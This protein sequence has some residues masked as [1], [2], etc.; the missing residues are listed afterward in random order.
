LGELLG[1]EDHP[2]QQPS[3]KYTLER[4]NDYLRGSV[5]LI[6]GS[7]AQLLCDIILTKDEDIV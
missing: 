6:T 1:R 4:F 2:N 7:S 5:L 3:P